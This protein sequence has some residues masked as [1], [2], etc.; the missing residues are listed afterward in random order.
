MIMGYTIMWYI[1]RLNYTEQFFEYHASTVDNFRTEPILV[2]TESANSGFSIGTK[3]IFVRKLSVMFAHVP[4][5]APESYFQ[6]KLVFM[7][8]GYVM[9]RY[10]C[11]LTFPRGHLLVIAK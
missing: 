4:T 6:E 3:I 1:G 11:R 8:I 2:L 9:M 10:I 5:I 7:I